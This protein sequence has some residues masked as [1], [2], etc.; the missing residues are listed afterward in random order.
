M[1]QLTRTTELTRVTPI[2]ARWFDQQLAATQ[3]PHGA[4]H[5]ASLAITATV[6]DRVVGGVTVTRRYTQ[7]KIDQLAIDP[8]YRGH[9]LGTR[10]LQ[11]VE[12]YARCEHLTTL[13]LS[14][15]SYQAAGFY[16][17]CGFTAFGE[18][19]DVPFAGVTTTYFVKRL[20]D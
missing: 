1:I 5:A 8:A 12:D 17:K 7:L 4:K 13:T 3:L 15:R 20:T 2:L 6:G 14:T 10:L 16:R 11:A 19:T 9:R 18:L